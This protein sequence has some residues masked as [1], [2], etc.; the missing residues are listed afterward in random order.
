MYVVYETGEKL[1]TD[2]F[3]CVVETHALVSGL[4]SH[5]FVVE[6]PEHQANVL[7]K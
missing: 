2:M 3:L 6:S 5:F 4:G 1:V 7:W